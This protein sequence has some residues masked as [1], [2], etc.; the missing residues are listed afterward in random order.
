[1]H[2][3]WTAMPAPA[4]IEQRRTLC[5]ASLSTLLSRAHYVIG[6]AARNRREDAI[7]QFWVTPVPP[8]PAGR[9]ER[10]RH[11]AR[12]LGREQA[13]QPISSA[14]SVPTSPLTQTSHSST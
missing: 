3:R 1:M 5:F 2:V 4:H 6:L 7:G 10:V 13:W 8:P 11:F 9:D 12:S 14:T